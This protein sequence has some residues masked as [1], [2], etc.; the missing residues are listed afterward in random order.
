MLAV[1]QLG[2]CYFGFGQP[3]LHGA[4]CRD[5]FLLRGSLINQSSV[6]GKY[7]HA[8]GGFLGFAAVGELGR[9][10]YEAVVACR[11]AQRMALEVEGGVGDADV[12]AAEQSAACIPA[13]VVRL[14]GVG[15][16]GYHVVLSPF[17]PA[18]DVYF[19]SHISVVGAANAF[20]VQIDVAHIHDASEI[21][22]Y[23]LVFHGFIGRQ[24]V[25]V[26]SLAHLFEAAA[27]Q[28]A[29]DIG[30]HVGVV[31]ALRGVGLHPGLFYLEVVGQTDAAPLAVVGTHGSRILHVACMESPALVDIFQG[32]L[33]HRWHGIQHRRQANG[34]LA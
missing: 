1:P 6:G 21:Q 29:L 10:V 19:E 5:A 9:D 22:Q 7:F 30:S 3:C 8:H 15:H 16:H 28:A 11:N 18:G 2:L 4:R 27:R 17:Q 33:C 20:A 23:A 34:S 12:H 14:T 25:A 13:R 26:P 32:A 31:G 24:V